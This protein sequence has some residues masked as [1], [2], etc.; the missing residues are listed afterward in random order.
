M[1]SA[2]GGD[3]FFYQAPRRQRGFL[4][5]FFCLILPIAMMLALSGGIFAIAEEPGDT[6]TTEATATDTST[7]TPAPEPSPAPS[8]AEDPVAAP[9]PT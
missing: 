6:A 2:H 7:E 4:T 1:S 3:E 9:E 5:R 8:P